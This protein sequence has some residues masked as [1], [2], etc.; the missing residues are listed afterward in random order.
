MLALEAIV[1]PQ[2]GP[3]GLATLRQR[4]PPENAGL[5]WL[6]TNEVW[7]PPVP[8]PWLH[9]CELLFSASQS[10]HLM[11]FLLKVLSHSSPLRRWLCLFYWENTDRAKRELLSLNL[12]TLP[13]LSGFVPRRTLAQTPPLP[14]RSPLRLS[15]GL[16]VC[17]VLSLCCTA[18]FSLS[19]AI[20]SF[21]TQTCHSSHLKNKRKTSPRSH[22][23]ALI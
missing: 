3:E 2:K 21:T 16:C 22:G 5:S 17:N 9:T 10:K 8:Q 15:S 6:G 18:N 14:L 23:T 4:N 1:R 20:K 7:F 11:S 12:L 19:E 13:R